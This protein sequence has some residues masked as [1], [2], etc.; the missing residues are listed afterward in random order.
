MGKKTVRKNKQQ[1]RRAIEPGD[2]TGEIVGISSIQFGQQVQD[3]PP[4]QT[5]EFSYMILTAT[6]KK[7]GDDFRWP[8]TVMIIAPTQLAKDRRS[9]GYFQQEHRARLLSMTI[10][11]TRAQFSDML[12][13]FELGL[14]K[15]FYFSI[16]EG[17][18][19][20]WALQSWGITTRFTQHSNLMT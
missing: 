11:V 2:W 3:G 18:D 4:K 10:S 8:A 15:D 17:V 16:E 7:D 14:P 12:R 9:A 5:V 13:S 6:I 20:V 19:G 1:S